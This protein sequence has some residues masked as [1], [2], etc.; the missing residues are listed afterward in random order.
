[1]ELHQ[2][3]SFCTAKETI[4]GIKRQLQNV[5]KYLQIIYWIKDCYQKYI[6]KS[7]K[8]IITN[9][10]SNLKMGRGTKEILSQG[11]YSTDM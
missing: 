1:M 5:R 4:N 11:R 9:L 7:Y 6:K 8:S 10:K 2:L 3:K